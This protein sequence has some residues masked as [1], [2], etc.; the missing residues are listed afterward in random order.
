MNSGEHVKRQRKQAAII[1]KFLSI[2]IALSGHGD[3]SFP[4]WLE[5]LKLLGFQANC[6]PE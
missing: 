6:E 1:F 3:F 2:T 5:N 4:T